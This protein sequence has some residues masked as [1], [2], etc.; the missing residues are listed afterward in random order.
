[1][2]LSEDL[3]YCGPQTVTPDNVAAAA[4]RLDDV[5]AVVYDTLPKG[6]QPVENAPTTYGGTL[7]GTA[8]QRGLNEMSHRTAAPKLDY[9]GVAT[10]S[11]LSGD[12]LAALGEHREHVEAYLA[13]AAVHASN[14]TSLVDYVQSL[15]ADA[16]GV[17]TSAEAGNLQTRLS[18]DL[19]N[20]LRKMDGVVRRS[21]PRLSVTG[22]FCD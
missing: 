9:Y 10:N 5:D 4:G 17:W 12:E 19:E 18:A 8:I 21:H 16:F 7:D 15:H 13:D 14:G 6:N 2:S 1:M 3:A 20:A 11:A 22:M